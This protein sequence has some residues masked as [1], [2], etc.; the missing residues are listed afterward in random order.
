[1]KKFAYLI[2]NLVVLIGPLSAIVFYRPII[3]PVWPALF[4]SLFIAAVIFIILDQWATG[5]FWYFNRKYLT[6]LFIGKLPVEEWLFFI[7]VPFACFLLW[8]NLQPLLP[9]ASVN[10]FWLVGFLFCLSILALISL[11]KHRTYAAAVIIGFFTVI[12]LDMLAGANLIVRQ[13]FWIFM[14]IVNL[15]TLIFNAYLVN[16]PIVRYFKQPK[17]GWQILNIPAE[18]F[19]YGTCLIYSNLF[20]YHL[21]ITRFSF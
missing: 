9:D 15:L 2:F 20:L 18:D 10:F 13:R 19:L 1:M 12:I 8:V 4:F 7:T 14:I 11:K 6:G 17:T 3:L 16:Q 21:F 5:R